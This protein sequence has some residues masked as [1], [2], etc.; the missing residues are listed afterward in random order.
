MKRGTKGLFCAN[1]G[2][3]RGG[4]FTCKSAWCGPCYTAKDNDRFHINRPVDESGFEQLEAKDVNRFLEARNGDHLVCSFQCDSCLFLMLKGRTPITDNTKDE[5]LLRCLRRANLDAFWTREPSTISANRRD[6]DRLVELAGEVG[7]DPVFEAMGPFPVNDDIQGVFVAIMMLQRSLDPGRHASYSQFQTIRKL[8]SAHSNQYM[9]SLRGALASAT[10][11]RTFGKSF[12]TQTPTNS[13]W[14]ERFSMGCLKR[15][16][17]VV[18][19]DL[20]ISIEVELALLDIIKREIIEA[21]G[22]ERDK[23]VM[24]G[25]F[26]SICFCGS[27]RGHEVFLTDLDGL[28]RYNMGEKYDISNKHVTIP[29]LGRFKGETGEKYHLTPMA[30]E[31]NSGIKLKFWVDLLLRMHESHG[32]RNGPAF[33]DS[34]G[35]RLKSFQMQQIILDLL[36]KIQIQ[37]P[38][39]ISPSVDVLEEYG[40]SR[41]FRRGATTHARNCDVSLADIKA[42]NRWRDQENAQGRSI[43]QPM[44]DHYTEVKQL[45]PTLLRFS[46]AL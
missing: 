7:I 33:C 30:A 31:T 21:R 1:F 24:A 46:K 15:M 28:Y 41:S 6:V 4:V 40:I 19:Q 2:Q 17:Q 16:G 14:F 27:F 45:L 44:T 34:K 13:L 25:A 5:F 43:N 26:T 9:A 22:W 32:R 38:S 18:K 23:L 36:L 42:A 3:S 12:L 37:Y 39:I 35:N 20:G 8:R 29:L 10:L 11:G